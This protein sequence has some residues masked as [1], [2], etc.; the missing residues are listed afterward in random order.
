MKNLSSCF[1]ETPAIHKID[2]TASA[3]TDENVN[4]V[5][6]HLKERLIG[7]WRRFD[8]NV[9]DRA[10]NQWRDR[11]CKCIRTKGRHFWH[12]KCFDWHLTV[13]ENSQRSVVLPK[14]WHVCTKTRSI[15]AKLHRSVYNKRRFV[16]FIL[17]NS[18]QICASPCKMFRGLTLFRTPYVHCVPEKLPTCHCPYL[19]QA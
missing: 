6:D 14:I 2:A 13:F 10:V 16:C 11:L 19:C 1:C 15:S 18:V 5:E 12:L 3:R 9:V 17:L 7:E 4:H 8:Q